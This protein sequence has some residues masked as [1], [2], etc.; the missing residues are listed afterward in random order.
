MLAWAVRS[1]MGGGF[2]CFSVFLSSLPLFFPFPL[3][4][5]LSSVPPLVSAFSAWLKLA[6]ALSMCR[7]CRCR[8]WLIWAAASVRLWLFSPCRLSSL[9]SLLSCFC[10]WVLALPAR[11]AGSDCFRLLH[12]LRLLPWLVLVLRQR[13]RLRWDDLRPKGIRQNA[14]IQACFIGCFFIGA[15]V[16]FYRFF[17]I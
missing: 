6:L 13:G 10:F 16:K 7:R 5:L 14:Q 3:S 8:L 11:G 2:G 17:E 15:T 4:S 12:G 1:G 9:R